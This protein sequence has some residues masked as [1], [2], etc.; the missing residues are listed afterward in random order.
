[1]ETMSVFYALYAG[2][3]NSENI[4]HKTFLSFEIKYKFK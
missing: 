1:M 4:I 2:A 3:E